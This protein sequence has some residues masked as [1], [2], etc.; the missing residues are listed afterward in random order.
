M[1]K[2]AGS[3][4]VEQPAEWQQMAALDAGAHGRGGGAGRTRSLAGWAT[5]RRPT[6]SSTR[7]WPM[8][9]ACRSAALPRHR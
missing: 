7:G 1:I 5:L 9:R 3:V 2:E 4:F 6:R 8:T